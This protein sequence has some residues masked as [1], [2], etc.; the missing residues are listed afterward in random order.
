MFVPG[1]KLK[2]RIAPDPILSVVCK[3]VEVFDEG[4]ENL[5]REMLKALPRFKGI[6]LAAPQVGYAIRMFVVGFDGG[7]T[8]VNPEIEM[9]DWSPVTIQEGCLSLPGQRQSITRAKHV[10]VKAKDVAGQS[11]T[12]E[13]KDFQAIVIQHELD[14]LDG[15]LMTDRM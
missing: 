9:V 2:L 5:S 6:G 8:F 1:Q 13:A 3:S 11:L 15:L 14:H 4:L 10:R 7:M 12:Y